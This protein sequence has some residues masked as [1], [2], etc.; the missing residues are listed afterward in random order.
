MLGPPAQIVDSRTTHI[1]SYRSLEL[2]RPKAS[3]HSAAGTPA[4]SGSPKNLEC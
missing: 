3:S 2:E 1:I 4:C